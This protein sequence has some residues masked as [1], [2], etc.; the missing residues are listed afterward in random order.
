MRGW[1][2]GLISSPSSRERRPKA[3]P[4]SPAETDRIAEAQ[5]AVMARA[6][7]GAATTTTPTENK[8]GAL[9]RH[10]RTGRR[11]RRYRGGGSGGAR[12]CYGGA[13]WH[14]S[15]LQRSPLDQPGQSA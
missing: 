10:H 15:S 1:I 11:G 5:H 9:A 4:T 14:R 12:A 6:P 13:G 8:K 3:H 7:N 2:D